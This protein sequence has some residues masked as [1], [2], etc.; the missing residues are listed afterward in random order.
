MEVMLSKPHE[1]AGTQRNPGD[2]ID[3]ADDIAHWLCEIGSAQPMAHA[4]K[5]SKQSNPTQE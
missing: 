2:V 1:H 5:P 4:T 3:L